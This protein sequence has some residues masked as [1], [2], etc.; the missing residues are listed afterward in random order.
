MTHL[1]YCVTV[2][3]PL[4][5]NMK[6]QYLTKAERLQF[7]LSENLKSI[8]VGLSLGDLYVHKQKRCANVR[9]CFEQGTVHESYLFHLYNLFQSYC[10]QAPK[11]YTRLPDKRTGK[12][13][14]RIL[15]KTYRV[16]LF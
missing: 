3:Y 16:T 14:S 9:L 6:K 13:Y 15:F 1:Q 10:M 2:S 7:V 8:L 11:V 4:I 5:T 12:I